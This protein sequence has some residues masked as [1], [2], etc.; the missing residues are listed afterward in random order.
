M[1]HVRTGVMVI[2]Y[3]DAGAWF[4]SHVSNYPKLQNDTENV[5]RAAFQPVHFRN[6]ITN[7]LSRSACDAF[8]FTVRRGVL[9]G[10]P[11]RRG[12]GSRDVDIENVIIRPLVRKREIYDSTRDTVMFSTRF[13]RT[14]SKPLKF[15]N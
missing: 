3:V 10:D 4:G 2:A 11:R 6:A 1:S 9:H 15:G 8:A 12:T 7:V 13:V 5:C 14:D